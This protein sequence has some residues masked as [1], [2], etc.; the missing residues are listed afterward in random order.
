MMSTTSVARVSFAYFRASL[1]AASLASVPELQKKARSPNE[2]STRSFARRICDRDLIEVRYLEQRGRLLSDGA[3]DLGIRV[4]ERVSRR[5]RRRSRDIPCRR[6]PRPAR[7][8]RGPGRAAPAR[9]SGRGV[10][11]LEKGLR[12]LAHRGLRKRQI[13]RVGSKEDASGTAGRSSG[14]PGPRGEPRESGGG[15]HPTATRPIPWPRPGGAWGPPGARVVTGAGSVAR[16]GAARQ[17][18]RE[19]GELRPGPARRGRRTDG[20][21]QILTRSDRSS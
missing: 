6:Y 17:R 2:W 20:E 18:G 4:A 8:R 1:I 10:A 9:S 19:A 21:Q 3:H 11:S 13:R 15:Q 7:P 5:S 12:V 14:R 16:A